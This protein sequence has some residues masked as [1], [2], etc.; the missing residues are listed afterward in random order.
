MVASAGDT[1]SGQKKIVEAGVET[2]P[3]NEA[4]AKN[5]RR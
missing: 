4:E 1:S 5:E 3:G 2:A